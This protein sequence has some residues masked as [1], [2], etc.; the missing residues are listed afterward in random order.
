M[1]MYIYNY[2]CTDVCIHDYINIH[3]CISTKSTNEKADSKN[4]YSS[5]SYKCKNDILTFK[6]TQ[7]VRGPEF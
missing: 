4:V 5:E 7:H 3:V 1:Y 2:V 6:K